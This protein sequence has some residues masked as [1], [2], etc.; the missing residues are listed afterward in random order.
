MS[1]LFET[2]HLVQI[3]LICDDIESVK[4]NWAE[5]LESD[6]PTTIPSEKY[7]TTNIQFLGEPAYHAC[8]NGAAFHLGNPME[9]EFELLRPIGRVPSE[10]E[11]FLVE[12]GTGLHHVA[13]RVKDAPDKAKKAQAA[14][15][16]LRQTGYFGE[17]IGR[18]AYLDAR[19]DLK[20]TLELTEDPEQPKDS[21]QPE[22]TP[23]G[24]KRPA[25]VIRIA[26][27]IRSPEYIGV[28]VKNLDEVL[29]AY[30]RVF[31]LEP[32][33]IK[34]CTRQ[35]RLNGSA[36][37]EIVRC[38]SA[39]IDFEGVRLNFIEPVS[40]RS[41]WSTSFAQ[42]GEGLHHLAFPVKDLTAA[43]DRYQK[44]GWA[45]L[46]IAAREDG[47]PVSAYLD[48]KEDLGC[49]LELIEKEDF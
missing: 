29:S 22:N 36:D 20:L 19:K 5:F 42:S 44:Q 45:P 24:E 21:E 8:T 30:K 38:R 1:N 31:D 9:V 33:A 14:G 12:H 49:I 23:A 40:E 35:A 41:V 7:R 6:V 43:L 26:E 2:N 11:N 48:T 32:A 15:L 46:Q 4:S 27:S 25:P 3:G 37:M 39:V 34:D 10:W 47:T 13:I 28:V 18:Y 17:G 16:V